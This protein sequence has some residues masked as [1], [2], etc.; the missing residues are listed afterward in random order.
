M[1]GALADILVTVLLL[2]W[3]M[4]L[5]M[6]PVAFDNPYGDAKKQVVLLLGMMG[7]PV[8]IFGLYW[9]FGASYFGISGLACLLISIM[10]VLFA[11]HFL[12][13][14]KWIFKSESV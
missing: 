4:V 8:P 11:M 10:A 6:S 9:L 2:A 12:G 1:M 3:P 13:Y 7:Y 14:L 5:M